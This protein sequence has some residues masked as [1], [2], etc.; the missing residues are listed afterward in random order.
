MQ[1]GLTGIA[2]AGVLAGLALV[3][4]TPS[5]AQSDAAKAYKANCTLC[6]ADNGS[7]SAPAGKALKAK[8]L[9]A[10]ETQKKPDAEL[11]DTIAK[12]KGKMPAF[13]SKLSPEMI[14]AL[15]AYIRQL[16]KK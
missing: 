5:R 9:R 16:A 11:A 7:G 14:N 1:M 15:V 8:D 12:G 13:G 4:A 2:R 6:H 3:A 10:D